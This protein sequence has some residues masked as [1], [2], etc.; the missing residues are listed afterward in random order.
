[1]HNGVAYHH[2]P[3]EDHRVQNAQQEDSQQE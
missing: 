2:R 3:I 1:L